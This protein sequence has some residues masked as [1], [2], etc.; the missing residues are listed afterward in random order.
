MENTRRFLKL[1]NALAAS[2]KTSLRSQVAGGEGVILLVEG[3]QA[4]LF[5]VAL[6]AVLAD[7]LVEIFWGK[8]VGGGLVLQDL[9]ARSVS[10]LS[11]NFFVSF[12]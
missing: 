9:K 11:A 7:G 3:G 4:L 8:A 2:W 5:E 1:V 12:C 6:R 10:R